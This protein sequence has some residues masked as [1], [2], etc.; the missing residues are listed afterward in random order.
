MDW[1]MERL[2]SEATIIAGLETRRTWDNVGV[3]RKE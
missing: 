3:K 2:K 1:N